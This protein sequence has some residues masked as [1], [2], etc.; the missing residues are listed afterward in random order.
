[1]LMTLQSYWTISEKQSFFKKR[2]HQLLFII[3]II[4]II[5]IIIF[6]IFIII[7]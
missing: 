5:I 4:I 2:D 7:V 6:I 1:M 3:F